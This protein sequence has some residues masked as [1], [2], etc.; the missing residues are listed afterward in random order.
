MRNTYRPL[1]I[2]STS[3]LVMIPAFIRTT[4]N[5]EINISI[6]HA[7]YIFVFSPI[8]YII[9]IFISRRT[10]FV[11]NTHWWDS[12]QKGPFERLS[13]CEVKY[14][15]TQTP[16]KFLSHRRH[17]LVLR[18]NLELI[19]S[20]GFLLFLSILFSFSFSWRPNNFEELSSLATV[21]GA[22]AIPGGVAAYI[23]R[24]RI[25]TRSRNRQAWIDQLR[26]IL[27]TLISDIPGWNAR[28]ISAPSPPHENLRS[29]AEKYAQHHT[30]LE[31]LLN[32]N[33]REHL[34]IIAYLW[35]LYRFDQLDQYGEARGKLPDFIEEAYE[36][37]GLEERWRTMSKK[38]DWEKTKSELVRLSNALLKREWEQIKWIR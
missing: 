27:A 1:L 37:L 6:F 23:G 24:A 20:C 14:L 26:S 30:K 4:I 21:L 7:F 34:A 8:F 18:Y 29:A 36:N 15:A 38:E 2:F 5:E 16:D 11:R 32:P 25:D 13:W 3:L 17:Y 28:W 31:L 19:F 22:L 12:S 9:S 10:E 35:K 33:E